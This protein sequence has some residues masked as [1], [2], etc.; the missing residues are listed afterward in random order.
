M[1]FIVYGQQNSYFE[2]FCGIWAIKLSKPVN[3][4]KALLDNEDKRK[5]L[6]AE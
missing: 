3:L 4:R 1:A 5:L 6:A 2:G